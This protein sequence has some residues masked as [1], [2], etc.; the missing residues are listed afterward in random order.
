[1]AASL[2]Q[3]IIII[4][5]RCTVSNTRGLCYVRLLSWD[6]EAERPINK[7]KNKNKNGHFSKSEQRQSSSSPK[8]LTTLILIPQVLLQQSVNILYYII[9][10]F[11]HFKI[12]WFTFLLIWFLKFTRKWANRQWYLQLPAMITPFGFG[13]PKVVAATVLSITRIRFVLFF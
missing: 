2:T 6:G 12:L 1:M 3:K 7:N 5:A 9:F 10:V 13:R 11:I 8:P 4:Y